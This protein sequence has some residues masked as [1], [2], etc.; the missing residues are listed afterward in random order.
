MVIVRIHYLQT[1]RLRITCALVFSD[2]IL[3]LRIYV[4]IA[5]IY[6]RCYAVGQHSLD[7]GTGAGSAAGVQ[8]Y[9]LLPH[10][11]LYDILPFHCS[12]R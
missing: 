4:R 3:L 10:R 7:Y 9:S 1:E 12:Q 8:K 5:V 6:D 11:S 2:L